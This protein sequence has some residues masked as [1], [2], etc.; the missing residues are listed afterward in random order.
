MPLAIMPNFFKRGL[1]V[2]LDYPLYLECY[3]RIIEEVKNEG[4]SIHTFTLHPS[5]DAVSQQRGTRE[6]S[7][8]MSARIKK[9]YATDMHDVRIGKTH[10]QYK[11][12]GIRYC[13]N[14]TR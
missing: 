8:E 13:A 10:R 7:P 14:H 6:I 1:N 4:L 5:L 9:L 3:S 2:V 12:D 11:F